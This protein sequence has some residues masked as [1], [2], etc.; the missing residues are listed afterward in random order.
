MIMKLDWTVDDLREKIQEVVPGFGPFKM[1]RKTGTSPQLIFLPDDIQTPS[2]IKEREG[3][4]R[5]MLYIVPNEVSL[6]IV[7]IKIIIMY[8]VYPLSRDHGQFTL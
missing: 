4:K 1:A 6:T 8:T 7:I 5:S 3:L 2:D